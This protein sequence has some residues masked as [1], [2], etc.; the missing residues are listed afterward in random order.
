VINIIFVKFQNFCSLNP[1]F[2]AFFTPNYIAIQAGMIINR[3]S[4]DLSQKLLLFLI[5][6]AHSSCPATSLN[7]TMKRNQKTSKN[8]EM[9]S[10]SQ[11][12]PD[13]F[14][15]D[16][17]PISPAFSA[18]SM[19]SN[20][21]NKRTFPSPDDNNNERLKQQKGEG[22]IHCR[23]ILKPFIVSI[24]LELCAENIS[25]VLLLANVDEVESRFDQLPFNADEDELLNDAQ[26]YADF[27]TNAS[28]PDL[29]TDAV[30][31]QARYEELLECHNALSQEMQQ[32]QARN[33]S[34]LSQMNVTSDSQNTLISP[35]T[36]I[37]YH[38]LALLRN[39][40]SLLTLQ[41]LK[42]LIPTAF[43][44]PS[45]E[46]LTHTPTR[47]L[48]RRATLFSKMPKTTSFQLLRITL[49]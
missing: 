44:E 10:N 34:I 48:S 45:L 21:S 46:C 2:L 20:G 1:F 3:K 14:S 17:R 26:D 31:L 5:N 19:N 39:P 35:P 47:L 28:A 42:S 30:D 25:F 27:T 4:F 41:S 12:S 36:C 15:L 49:T 11:H 9:S 24:V 18:C 38:I 43:L 37:L 13:L 6:F 7:H 16:Q 22:R 32:N 8:K 23:A 33:K 29:P 40:Q